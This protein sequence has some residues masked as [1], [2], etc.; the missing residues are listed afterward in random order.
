M[1]KVRSI[2]LPSEV[3]EEGVI[4]I[5]AKKIRRRNEQYMRVREALDD[6]DTELDKLE[7]LKAKLEWQRVQLREQERALIREIHRDKTRKT[8]VLQGPHLKEE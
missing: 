6:I 4:D 3:I 7:R 2:L 5:D 8:E 1:T